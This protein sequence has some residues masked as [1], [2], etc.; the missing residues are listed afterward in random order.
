M[1]QSLRNL[2]VRSRQRRMPIAES[3]R[4]FPV[5]SLESCQAMQPSSSSSP[6]PLYH[7]IHQFNMM[8]AAAVQ[9]QQWIKVGQLEVALAERNRLVEEQVLC[10]ARC[11]LLSSS[12]SPISSPSSYPAALASNSDFSVIQEH[13][14]IVAVRPDVQTF[15]LLMAARIRVGDWEGA[16]EYFADSRC[17]HVAV[18][19]ASLRLAMGAFRMASPSQVWRS[20][21]SC[22][23]SYQHRILSSE[24]LH[25][26][27]GILADSGNFEA[28]VGV[29]EDSR[30]T[31][32]LEHDSLSVVSMASERLGQWALAVQLAST[33]LGA[34]LPLPT[35]RSMVTSAV[36]CLCSTFR[37]HDVLRIFTT[38]RHNVFVFEEKS[39]ALIAHAAALHA[40]PNLTIGLEVLDLSKRVVNGAAAPQLTLDII[41][42]TLY[43]IH[44][45][46][47]HPSS[48]H[49]PLTMRKLFSVGDALFA[50]VTTMCST[51][52]CS[53]SLPPSH[54][55]LF[56]CNGDTKAML[57][58][59]Q[60]MRN[61][62][63]VC[64]LQMIHHLSLHSLWEEGWSI[65]NK[66]AGEHSRQRGFVGNKSASVAT[67]EAGRLC[68]PPVTA[69]AIKMM[70]E[71]MTLPS[72]TE[73]N[74][75]LTLGALK[76][77][78]HSVQSD[79]ITQG[80]ADFIVRDVDARVA[81]TRGKLF[82]LGYWWGQ[83]FKDPE[84]ADV[85]RAI[86]A[87]GDEVI[88][89]NRVELLK[90]ISTRI[91]NCAEQWQ[92]HAAAFLAQH[93]IGLPSAMRRTQ[94]ERDCV[95]ETFAPML[96]L[97]PVVADFHTM[98][99][100]VLDA[101]LK[102]SI[103]AARDHNSATMPTNAERSAQLLTNEIQTITEVCGVLQV[104]PS[105][106]HS[107][108]VNVI[109]FAAHFL[110][111]AASVAMLRSSLLSNELLEMI[112]SKH[113]SDL[114]FAWGLTRLQLAE[115]SNDERITI[116]GF[117]ASA[118]ENC[119]GS[120]QEV[121]M[122]ADSACWVIAVDPVTFLNNMLRSIRRLALKHPSSAS[123]ILSRVIGSIFHRRKVIKPT[124]VLERS[125]FEMLRLS[126]ALLRVKCNPQPQPDDAAYLWILTA[127]KSV[128]SNVAG[129]RV[130]RLIEEFNEL[131]DTIVATIIR[132]G[133]R[134]AELGHESSKF[135]GKY[136]EVLCRSLI[137]AHVEGLLALGAQHFELI[138]A[139]PLRRETFLTFATV[140]LS[141][142]FVAKSTCWDDEALFRRVMK[143][144]S[145]HIA[146]ANG[147]ALALFEA[148][149]THHS[150]LLHQ[151]AF[152]CS[153]VHLACAAVSHSRSAVSVDHIKTS[154]AWRMWLAFPVASLP[155]S[156][157]DPTVI[158]GAI[159]FARAAFCARPNAARKPLQ[160]WIMATWTKMN[161]VGA[162]AVSSE[163]LSE[164]VAMVCDIRSCDA[165]LSN[166]LADCESGLLQFVQHS[167][168]TFRQRRV[169]LLM[170]SFVQP[171]LSAIHAA[172][173]SVFKEL[174]MLDC[175]ED[176][177]KTRQHITK[178]GVVSLSDGLRE[179]G[180]TAI[181]VALNNVVNA[182][183]DPS[184]TVVTVKKLLVLALCC[185][186]QS[187]SLR[188]TGLVPVNVVEKLF[189]AC[190]TL[191][192]GPDAL[193]RFVARK[194]DL[195][196]IFSFLGT[197]GTSFVALQFVRNSVFSKNLE[198]DTASIVAQVAARVRE[199]LLHCSDGGLDSHKY[200]CRL[201]VEASQ[202]KELLL[203][204]L[205]LNNRNA[206]QHNETLLLDSVPLIVAASWRCDNDSQVALEAVS[207]FAAVTGLQQRFERCRRALL[208]CKL[209]L[210]AQRR[211]GIHSVED[212]ILFQRVVLA[213]WF[214]DERQSASNHA[215]LRENWEA[216][217]QRIPT[218]VAAND[219]I[220]TVATH[221]IIL[222]DGR[223]TGS[224]V[225]NYDGIFKAV[226][227]MQLVTQ[228][229]L[230]KLADLKMNKKCSPAIEKELFCRCTF[231][232]LPARI[233]P[234]LSGL[235]IEQCTG[236]EEALRLV[237]H[238]LGTLRGAPTVVQRFL[239]Y[240][241]LERERLG[242]WN[243]SAL[244]GVKP[245][246][247]WTLAL[248][249]LASCA[250]NNPSLLSQ[251]HLVEVIRHCATQPNVTLQLFEHFQK[252][253]YKRLEGINVLLS[254][255]RCARLSNRRDV[256][257]T[258]LRY[259]L[260]VA[261]S[262]SANNRKHFISEF[263]RFPATVLS[264]TEKKRWA[265]TMQSTISTTDEEELVLL[266]L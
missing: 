200:F 249:L 251:R 178:I 230:N 171:Q 40:M 118:I 141:H 254:L 63:N 79:W 41:S 85:M 116:A 86:S 165:Q 131:P 204:V 17:E 154:G 256:A 21:L 45:L 59:F 108:I 4:H 205:V 231:E 212:S 88:S 201:C 146:V 196:L 226:D 47:N 191:F 102:E 16:L 192:V 87:L 261:P 35:T 24:T 39:L 68:P 216:D 151:E 184:L 221:K 232:H 260:T 263:V 202:W 161:E 126:F 203:V 175:V 133:V 122:F 69:I 27:L 8:L 224:V 237:S 167:N 75:P 245:N 13:K 61:V 73:S 130:L 51:A 92:L 236:W 235:A 96:R 65:L 127:L 109:L 156:L 258:A 37:F 123:D 72:A 233:P 140:S 150:S 206:S 169:E 217:L 179:A 158:R 187:S 177:L 132:A 153:L 103:L 3:S 243:R 15:Q 197:E 82:S 264:T 138:S 148:L 182:P 5:T 188:T 170:A 106:L 115:L 252:N 211:G 11:A 255:L 218:D 22:F 189:S 67:S 81:H 145:S 162:G 99:L 142:H 14:D 30:H 166:A 78:R 229:T 246:L 222:L 23:R 238:S 57:Q 95:I 186:T 83:D 213:S 60:H 193:W 124:L 228:G 225:Q 247:H 111:P 262:L 120:E 250:Q 117:I 76:F 137:V 209:A 34:S 215:V 44:R 62:D 257:E 248:D 239:M 42:S 155:L 53:A 208:R 100:T 244:G 190:P 89:E 234:N 181:L 163:L 74:I 70:F 43:S 107:T 172:V 160:T 223:T 26:L 29:Y 220:D 56:R 32:P 105:F 25:E 259:F 58:C 152:C 80:C 266:S 149:A 253:R 10:D 31:I 101:T 219:V 164:F 46:V 129:E 9:Q 114:I 134:I 98:V 52:V 28:I 136:G 157:D 54:Q 112:R 147:N 180:R 94:M 48:L 168:G 183:P 7:N 174:N 19:D 33:A 36:A 84:A 90:S 18:T 207:L 97:R 77:L 135:V 110:P 227:V 214:L 159:K 12:S 210:R 265:E 241:V 38:I 185:G 198:A 50:Q 113:S 71:R 93:L 119:E 2:V 195:S 91:S 66:A 144:I 104:S 55:L 128:R 143:R 20:A 121:R 240:L 173:N 242:T 49:A 64:V 176:L 1:S 139:L 6:V 194:S 199:A 125:L